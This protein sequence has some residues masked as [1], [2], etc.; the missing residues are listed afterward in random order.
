MMRQSLLAAALAL[1]LSPAQA[2]LF[3]QDPPRQELEVTPP[4]SFDVAS[5][6]AFE[7][8]GDQRLRYAVVPD[9]LQ[10][11]EDGLLR[12]VLV[13]TSSG[14]GQN[15]LF[16][17][18]DCTRGEHKTLARWS[19]HQQQWREVKS[20]RWVN[21]DEARSAASAVLSQGIFCA[22]GRVLGS[23]EAMLRELQRQ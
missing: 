8:P 2:G 3:G 6:E 21:V 16:E 22:D 20:P 4:A 18:L 17:A 1:A 23:R 13:A 11:G 15:I 14:G 7:M 9:S 10:V 5:A 12:Y 19:S